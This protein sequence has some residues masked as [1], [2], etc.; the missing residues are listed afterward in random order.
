MP[1]VGDRWHKLFMKIQWKLWLLWQPQG[2]IDLQWENVCLHH[3]SFSF[4]RMFLKLADKMDMDEISDK[5]ENRL[6]L[7]INLRVTTPW[8]LKTLLFDF[9]IS[10][11]HSVL[12]R[13]SWNLQIRW[14]WMKS[15]TSLKTG[16]I[17]SLILV[18]SPWLLKKPLFDFVIS[19]THSVLSRSF[20]HLQIRDM[21]EILDKIE[22]WPDQIIN[23]RVT[24]P[25]FLKKPLFDF[26]VSVT[27]SVLLRYSWNLQIR[28]TWIKSRTSSKTGQIE[29][30]FL[31]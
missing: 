25:W 9:V 4:D 6:D 16:Q 19:I 30:L 12:I 24:S 2:S 8:L 11:T 26:V 7:I 20:C 22:N 28:W 21:N 27:H 23:L 3:N 5:I 1:L 15:W 10:V 17:R 29:S 18:T 14:I 31:E 13:C